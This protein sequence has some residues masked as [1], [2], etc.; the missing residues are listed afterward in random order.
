MAA[1]MAAPPG[2]PNLNKEQ[3]RALALLARIPHGITED[4]L[5]PDGV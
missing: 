5:M 2:E 1:S 3:R 4:T